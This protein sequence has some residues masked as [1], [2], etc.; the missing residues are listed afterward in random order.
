[1]TSATRVRLFLTRLRYVFFAKPHQ[2]IDDELAFHLEQLTQSHVDSGMAPHDAHRQAMIEPGGIEAARAR[3]REQRPTHFIEVLVQDLRFSFRTFRRNR[4][5]TLTVVATLMLGIGATTA[6]FSVVDRILFRSLPYKHADQ[7]VS[8]G[9]DAPIEPNEF[10]LGGSYYEWQDNQRPFVGMTSEI[11][12]EPCDLTEQRPLRLS[13]AHVE[14]NFLPTLG[15]ALSAGRNFSAAEDTPNGPKVALISSA[16]WRSH[17]ALDP[18]VV[19]RVL[20]VDGHAYEVIGVLPADFEMPR[21]QKADVLLP[22]ALDVAAQRR[23]NPGRTMWAFARLKPGVSIAQAKEQLQPLFDYSLKEAPPQF[24]REVH[25]QVRSLRDRQMQ[26]VRAGAWIL[27]GLV[28]A[29]L[30]IACA[31]VASLMLARATRR[32]KEVAVRSAL[33]ASRWRLV[34]QAITESFILG[35][36]GMVMGLGFAAILL[37]SLRAAAPEGLPFLGKATLDSRLLFS[38][39]AAALLSAVLFGVGP[40]SSRPMLQLLSGRSF[41]TIDQA[42]A[43]RWLVVG[44]LAASMVLLVGSALLARNFSRLEGQSF[45]FDAR[46]VLTVAISLG[47][48]SYPTAVS[49]EAFFNRL[50][51]NLRYGP[52]ITGLAISDSLPPGGE[53]HDQIFAS[54][55]VAGRPPSIAGT[56]GNVA[57]RWVTPEYFHLLDI[58]ILRGPGF[59]EEQRGSKE[60][61]V[62]LSKSLAARLFP[63]QDPIGQQVLLAMGA[64]AAENPRYTVSGVAEDV[65]NGGLAAGDEPE[66][67]RLRREE[68]EDWDR[69]ATIIL[70]T[71]LP[72][73][74]VTPWI[75][76]QV[77]AVD[78]TVP[79][80]IDTLT[81]SLA[82]LADQPRFETLLVSLFAAIGLTLAAVG[83]YGVIAFLVAQR[84]QEIGVRMV[85]G[86][87]Q[88]DIL[89]LF[90]RSGLRML[91]PGVL[92]GLLLSLLLS[93]LL[94]SVLFQ[95][96][97]RDPA[98]LAAAAGLLMLTAVGATVIP[99]R[100]AMKVEPSVAL[101]S[102]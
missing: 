68:P 48:N 30:L 86:A 52:G 28:L 82:E 32:M 12:V 83:L 79:I 13:C 34:Q 57:W 55:A 87:S 99:A 15:V 8:V 46:N 23:A 96:S 97:P 100:A 47:E 36:A 19:G 90:I 11:G 5:F 7:L 29:V 22:E 98:A 50:E 88:S 51:R 66:Y 41:G 49:Q 20:H 3:A 85:L 102:E 64:P 10:M 26:N 92:L 2:E 74:T 77:A 54:L 18:A 16:M 76:A 27:F 56:G 59:T 1:M 9:L 53:H 72:V 63:T 37:Q 25:L 42:R 89:A 6:V 45:G 65:K 62:V 31:N 14:A 73:R 61:F 40:A 70:K 38:S 101:R 35:F 39:F 84:T 17:F 81:E 91:L 93:K 58:P 21:L 67:Y 75:R 78:P 94:S 44:Q 60:R 33:G 95:V 69:A 24:R 43:R 4:V 71:N 80:R